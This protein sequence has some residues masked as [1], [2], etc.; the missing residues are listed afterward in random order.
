MLHFL[1][2]IALFFLFCAGLPVHGQHLRKPAP[3]VSVN[4]GAYSLR[5]IHLFSFTSNQASLARLKSSGVALFGERRFMMEELSNYTAAI[6]IVN[7]LGNFGMKTVYSGFSSY[8]ESQIGL[9]YGRKLDEKLDIGVQ[10][11]YNGIR[12]AGYGAVAALSFEFGCIAHLTEKIHTGFH[13]NNPV[14]GRFGHD[15]NEKIASVYTL[16]LGYDVSEIFFAGTEIVKE[17]K[18]PVQII[19]GVKYLFAERLHARAGISTSESEYW[20]GIG[21]KWQRLQIDITTSV[22][23]QLGLTP[24]LQLVYHFKSGEE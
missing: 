17:E 7:R 16:G 12:A 23:Q 11:N 18:Q 10:F 20:M 15:K 13:V 5:H 6:C 3:A 4:P 9:A 21:F 24:S 8:N 19:L 1:L 2:H 14:G 22:H